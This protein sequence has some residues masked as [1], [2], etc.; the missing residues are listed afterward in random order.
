MISKNQIKY[1]RQLE[2][3]KFRHREGLFVAEGTKVVGDLLAHYQPHSIFAT[4][5]WLFSNATEEIIKFQVPLELRSL[6]TNGTQESSKL[7]LF[8]LTSSV[9]SVF[10]SIPSKSSPSSPSQIAHIIKLKAQSS[11]LKV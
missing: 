7:L 3:K 11:K 6:A 10:S 5:E 4:P 1:I 2:Q 9:V 8:L